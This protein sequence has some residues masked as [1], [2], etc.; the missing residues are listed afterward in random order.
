MSLVFS[1]NPGAGERHL[2]RQYH[3]PLFPSERRE[4]DT[5]R[6]SD[7][8]FADEQEQEEF[9]REFHKLLEEVAQLETNE[10][11][12]IMLELKSRLD[13][14]YEQCSGLMGEHEAEK[15]A[16][17]KLVTVIMNAIQHSA[18]GDSEAELNLRE[19]EQARMSHYQLLQAPLVADLLRPH[20]PI[21]Q[22]ELVA[23]LLTESEEAVNAAFQLFDQTQQEMLCQQAKEL[24]ELKSA[25]QQ[26]L[27]EAWKRLEF[28]EEKIKP[29]T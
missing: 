2:Q 13:Q 25:E 18:Q 5:Q 10:G 29:K 6:L 19:E 24:L 23:T 7:A 1:S 12:E 11:S 20:S 27:P 15:Q 4:F 3:N 26:D 16:I 22:D 9:T 8:R 28:M 14:A 21:L 17:T